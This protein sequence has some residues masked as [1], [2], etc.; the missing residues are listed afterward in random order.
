M[1]WDLTNSRKA[2]TLGKHFLHP[3]VVKVFLLQKVV[4]ILEDVVVSSREVRRIW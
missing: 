2:Q 4:E 3:A 1:L